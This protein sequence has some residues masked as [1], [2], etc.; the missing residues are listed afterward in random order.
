M[1]Q[2]PGGRTPADSGPRPESHGLARR[3]ETLA[4]LEAQR[5]GLERRIAAERARLREV[6]N[7]GLSDIEAALRAS[8][9][10]AGLPVAES[11]RKNVTTLEFGGL[12]TVQLGYEE[13]ERGRWLEVGA[14]AGAT[15]VFGADILPPP[16]AVVALV[17]E[18]LI[19]AQSGPPPDGPD[20]EV[21]SE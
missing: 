10:S 18:L 3:T 21:C 20:P 9:A 2:G 8:A 4:E 5:A 6:W 12:V 1:N 13:G 15:A 11:A 19:Y 17:C 14:P 16:A 7:D